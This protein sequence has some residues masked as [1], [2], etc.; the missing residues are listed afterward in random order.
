MV[1]IFVILALLHLEENNAFIKL[2]QVKLDSGD[3]SSLDIPKS[4]LLRTDRH[5]SLE[6]GVVNFENGI[7]ICEAI[8]LLEMLNKRVKESKL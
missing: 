6:R 8:E 2:S 1:F 4:V 3:F 5:V 7:I